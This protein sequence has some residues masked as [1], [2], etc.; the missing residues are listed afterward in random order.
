VKVLAADG[1]SCE[2][3]VLD[4]AD[5]GALVVDGGDGE[6][7]LTSAEISLRPLEAEKGSESFP[8]K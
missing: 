6:R 3:Q 8:R 7:R 1:T 4:V 2:A 5:D